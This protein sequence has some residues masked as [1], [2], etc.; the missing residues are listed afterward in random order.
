MI[1]RI[2]KESSI[3]YPGK[4]GP[5]IFTAGCNFKCGFCHNAQLNNVDEFLDED[6][7]LESIK[8]KVNSG[9]Y[10][11]VCITGGEPTLHKGLKDFLIKLKKMG[12]SVKLDSNGT[13]PKVLKELLEEGLVDYIA[14][15]IKG[16]KELYS[17][18]TNSDVKIKD[19]EE[20]IKLI[21]S[22]PTGSFEFRTTIPF[23]FKPYTRI[24]NLKE[25]EEM[26]KWVSSLSLNKGKWNTQL[27]VARHKEDMNDSRLCAQNLPKELHKTPE[28]YAEKIKKILE[29]NGFKSE[30]R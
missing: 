7:I 11:G 18:I 23:L 25:A 20:S 29:K 27:F 8:V 19:I 6:E 28:S 30:V 21:S 15:D 9:W 26:I 1:A 2:I 10:N 5:L 13:N 17:E 24:L 12:L 16:P 22:L 3:D 14:M 4:F